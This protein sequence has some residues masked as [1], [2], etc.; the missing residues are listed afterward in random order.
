MSVEAMSRDQ[1]RG[2]GSTGLPPVADLGSAPA[3]RMEP[4]P[5]GLTKQRLGF[6]LVVKSIREGGRNGNS[7][8][9][10]S[11]PRDGFV[12]ERHE[13]PDQRRLRR[14]Q[15]RV[16]ELDSTARCLG[17]RGRACLR[18]RS[19]RDGRTRSVDR[20]RGRKPHRVRHARA[21][22]RGLEGRA[23]PLRAALRV[24][25]PDNRPASGR[26][27]GLD[28]GGIQ[29][30]RARGACAER[31]PGPGPGARLLWPLVDTQER[32]TQACVRLRVAASRP[33]MVPR[34]GTRRRRG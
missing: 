16:A 2:H 22:G 32:V 11:L 20:V 27:R 19:A 1:V 13:P 23:L 14:E 8:S 17:E 7:H 26:D 10:G 25:H 6:M 3:H 33:R 31:V 24:L 12:A 34:S 4:V 5:Q 30:R 15:R 29:E 21:Q 18:L 28:Q 9:L